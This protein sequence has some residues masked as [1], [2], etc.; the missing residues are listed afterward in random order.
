MN[1]V[2]SASMNILL[3]IP[4]KEF[5]TFRKEKKGWH[6][7]AGQNEKFL[8]V[9]AFFKKFLKMKAG[10]KKPEG[11]VYLREFDRKRFE[12]GLC[13][14]F[15]RLQN[16]KLEI[17]DLRDT[18]GNLDKTDTT[19]SPFFLYFMQKFTLLQ[20]PGLHDPPMWLWI[21]KTTERHAQVIHY[22][23][24][25]MKDY[26]LTSST[27]YIHSNEQL[28]ANEPKGKG[29]HCEEYLAFLLKKG[30]TLPKPDAM[31]VIPKIDY[32]MEPHKYNESQF[33]LC[34]WELRMEFW[35]DIMELFCSPGDS[36][37]CIFGGTKT[38]HAAYVSSTFQ[39]FR[40]LSL[41]TSM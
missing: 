28:Y 8:N 39:L 31:Y 11:K 37:Y 4:D 5:F 22:V 13:G 25:H 41:F 21:S 32:Y 23:E 20:N 2:T 9:E 24:R 1:G 34:D 38:M 36:V 26:A 10:F 7:R 33:S 3:Q 19:R 12:F 15:Q 18:L 14:E 17:I 30:M 27:Y 40:L 16:L 6:V 29:K 35:L